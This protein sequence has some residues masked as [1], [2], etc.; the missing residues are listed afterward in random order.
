[1]SRTQVSFYVVLTP[2]SFKREREICLLQTLETRLLSYD[3]QEL[4]SGSLPL[5]FTVKQRLEPERFDPVSL[6]Q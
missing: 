4:L 1:M 6:V 3:E 5:C 2:F